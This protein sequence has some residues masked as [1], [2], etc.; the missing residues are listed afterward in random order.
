MAFDAFL[1]IDGIVGESSDG[2]I[3]LNS[4]SFG[5]ENP[6]SIG[7]ATGGA[8]AGKVSFS[9]F[10]FTS[11]VGAQSPKILESVLTNKALGEVLLTVTDKSAANGGSALSIKFSDVMLSTYKL[12][13]GPA[14][15]KI[16]DGSIKIDALLPA[17]QNGA[18]TESV[19]F[20][21][22]QIEFQTQGSSGTG[23][24]TGWSVVTNKAS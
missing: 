24:T 14:S 11:K 9:D 22:S 12:S 1:K 2:T 18:P 5:V 19:S 10:N 6:N 15:L 7:S 21:F 13:E 3:E 16:D 17:V 23:S 8:G 20:N 4:F